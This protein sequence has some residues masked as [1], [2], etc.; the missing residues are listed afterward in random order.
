MRTELPNLKEYFFNGKPW[1]TYEVLIEMKNRLNRPDLKLFPSGFLFDS[2]TL[3]EEFDEDFYLWRATNLVPFIKEHLSKFV[4]RDQIYLD[5]FA[6]NQFENCFTEGIPNELLDRLIEVKTLMISEKVNNAGELVKALGALGRALTDVH[7]ESSSLEQ[8]FFDRL[9]E[10]CPILDEL[11]IKE[12]NQL[13]PA[14]I[15]D[16]KSLK[17][18][19]FYQQIDEELVRAAFQ[20][21]EYFSSFH[22]H[23]QGNCV[24]LCRSARDHFKLEGPSFV[25]KIGNKFKLNH[26]PYSP[27][28]DL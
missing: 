11:R 9:P 14:F 17:C 13:N 3:P 7:I 26:A 28:D 21:Y 12:E 1:N 19:H 24:K 23:Q 4:V 16:F 8:E 10:Q 2:E 20:K 27:L 6:F 15:L 22:F 18:V 25:S 5:L